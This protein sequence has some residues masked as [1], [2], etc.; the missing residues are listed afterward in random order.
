[1]DRLRLTP[2]RINRVKFFAQMALYS[3][4]VFSL[5][6]VG[7]FMLQLR[8]TAKDLEQT[9][10]EIRRTVTGVDSALNDPYKGLKPTLQNVNAILLQVGNAADE[11]QAAAREQREALKVLNVKMNA[12]LDQVNTDLKTFDEVQ[13]S[14]K[15]ALDKLPALLD[16]TTKTVAS[17]NKLISDPAIPATLG[18]VNKVTNDVAGVTDQMNKST[19]PSI[20]KSLDHVEKILADG[21]HKAHQLAYPSKRQQIWGY[22][23][24]VLFMFSRFL[25][26]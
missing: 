5:I 11:T 23:K 3:A 20:N 10:V 7:V 17:T 22:T 9:S 4:G 26:F 24:E 8:Q 16:E 2:K 14:T 15:A 1:M 21:E 25:T 18:N 6:A 19:V 13:R 12:V